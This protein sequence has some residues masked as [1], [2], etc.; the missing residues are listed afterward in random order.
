MRVLLLGFT[1]LVAAAT[2]VPQR[3]RVVAITIDDLQIGRASCR[4]RV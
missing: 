4:E 2:A 3:E 1:L